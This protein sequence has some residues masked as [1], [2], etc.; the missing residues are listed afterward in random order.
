MQYDHVLKKMNFD[1]VARVGVGLQ[2]IYLRPRCCILDSLSFD[3]QHY[4]ILKKLNFD[5]LTPSSESCWGVCR[6]NICFHVA[7]FSI[8]F[9]LICNMTMF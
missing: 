6:Q 8:L 2:E 7:A 5:L 9:N 4:T 1:P 3:L